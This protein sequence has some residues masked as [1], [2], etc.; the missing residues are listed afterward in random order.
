MSE[1]ISKEWIVS[2]FDNVTIRLDSIDKANDVAYTALDKRLESMNEFRQ[3]LKD[4]AGTFVTRPEHDMVLVDV[5]SLR[6]SRAEMEGKASLMSVYI[7]W[8]LAI[9]GIIVSIIDLLLRGG[10]R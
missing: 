5:R 1:E 6:E 2:K 10:G 7:A 8:S 4:Q 9:L 3:A